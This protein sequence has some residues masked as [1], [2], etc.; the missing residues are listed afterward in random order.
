MITL[1]TVYA[2]IVLGVSLVI[3]FASTVISIYLHFNAK[4][5]YG[6]LI[7][8][9]LTKFKSTAE[10]KLALESGNI[11]QQRAGIVTFFNSVEI[12]ETLQRLVF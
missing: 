1:C 12:W 8:H 9:S 7:E 5:D 11:P 2:Y 6:E 3:I 10:L 4:L